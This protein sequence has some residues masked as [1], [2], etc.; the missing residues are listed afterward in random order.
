M[1][2]SF[3]RVSDLIEIGS[4]RFHRR[5]LGSLETISLSA[6]AYV[7]GWKE[8]LRIC[9]YTDAYY[10]RTNL[11]FPRSSSAGCGSLTWCILR[12]E[13]RLVPSWNFTTANSQTGSSLVRFF[14]SAFVPSLRF[15]VDVS[16]VRR[17]VLERAAFLN[18]EW[19]EWENHAIPRN[20]IPLY[21]ELSHLSRLVYRLRE[22]VTNPAVANETWR[23][24]EDVDLSGPNENFSLD[25]RC[26][27]LLLLWIALASVIEPWKLPVELFPSGRISFR[28]ETSAM[29][30]FRIGIDLWRRWFYF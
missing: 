9:T 25:S 15:L 6:F 24:G 12:L 18:R 4:L 5:N 17:A 19:N 21:S 11:H 13:F 20:F 27:C 3:P 1:V 28:W 26:N 16:N 30:S 8:T 2:K 23:I 10:R 29:E 14:V 22:T 7:R